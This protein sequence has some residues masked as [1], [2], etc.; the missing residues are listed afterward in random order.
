LNNTKKNHINKISL[1][2]IIILGLL[3]FG[4]ILVILFPR[5]TSAG[6]MADIYQNGN[7]IQ[8]IPL[9]QVTDSYSFELHGENGCT[10]VIEVRPG[11]IAIVSADCP[12]KLCVHQGAISNSLLPITCLPN[13]VVIQLRPADE[14]V[15]AP[16]PGLEGKSG[17]SDSITPDII[18]Y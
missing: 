18:T 5:E 17:D 3:V 4:S 6:Y 1:V 7:L 13:R 11:S 14:N 9:Y 8:S 15:S 16:N 10:N 12:D 2:I